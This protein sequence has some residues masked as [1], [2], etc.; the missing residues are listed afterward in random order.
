M[1]L[2]DW[3]SEHLGEW[4]NLAV[5][6]IIVG[7]ITA[8]IPLIVQAYK[9]PITNPVT[10]GS[11]IA[12]K[13]AAPQKSLYTKCL[14]DQTAGLVKLRPVLDANRAAL[15]K[16]RAEYRAGIIFPS[17]RGMEEACGTAGRV[18]IASEARMQVMEA[19][20]LKN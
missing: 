18:L 7:S 1:G 2:R 10:T 19:P 15:A 5:G 13:A 20:C 8:A 16:C 12:P 6:T 14:E 11:I 9:S 3:I 4:G 17:D